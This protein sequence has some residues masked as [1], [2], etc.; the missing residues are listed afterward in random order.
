MDKIIKIEDLSNKHCKECTTMLQ[1]RRGQPMANLWRLMVTTIILLLGVLGWAGDC[2][3]MQPHTTASADDA[4]EKKTRAAEKTK[5]RKPTLDDVLVSRIDFSVKSASAAAS[6][7]ALTDAVRKSL[8]GVPEDFA[9]VI[10]GADLQ[11]EGITKNQ[12]IRNIDAKRATVAEVLTEIAIKM[13]PITTVRDPS[14]PNQKVVWTVAPN[15]RDLD[16]KRRVVLI[17]TRSAAKK[18]GYRLPAAFLP[19]AERMGRLVIR[20]T[21]LAS[22]ARKLEPPKKHEFKSE[23]NS[24]ETLEVEAKRVNLALDKHVTRPATFSRG[25]C[26][27]AR[28]N[29]RELVVLFGIIHQYDKLDSVGNKQ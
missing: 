16:K 10:V 6:F 8:P 7:D 23:I 25:G 12:R 29:F 21:P 20:G 27:S 11:M 3:W 14:E 17:T 19:E 18:K 2:P 24:R 5:E 1:R 9:I 4:S 28:R 13:N 26:K 15:L 22:A